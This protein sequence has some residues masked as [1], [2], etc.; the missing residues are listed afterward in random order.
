MDFLPVTCITACLCQ[1]YCFQEQCLPNTFTNPEKSKREGDRRR[2]TGA[3]LKGLD[4]HIF[5]PEILPKSKFIY[6]K[7]SLEEIKK[8][9]KNPENQPR[10]KPPPYFAHS[11]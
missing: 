9:V 4:Y 6:F 3:V 5:L 1:K 11:K 2:K 8:G 7:S 10:T